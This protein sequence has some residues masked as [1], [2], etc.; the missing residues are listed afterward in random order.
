LRKSKQV[1]CNFQYTL[2]TADNVNQANEHSGK[3]FELSVLKS[4]QVKMLI[5]KGRATYF[6]GAVNLREHGIFCSSTTY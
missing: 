5:G 6:P 1:P 3:E 2:S 4:I